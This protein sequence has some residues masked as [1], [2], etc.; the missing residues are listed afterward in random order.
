MKVVEKKTRG[1]VI[2]RAGETEGAR[3]ATGVFPASAR[4]RGS[5]RARKHPKWR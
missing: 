4:Q 2:E 3:R 1:E 5:A